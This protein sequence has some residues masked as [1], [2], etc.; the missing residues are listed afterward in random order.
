MNDKISLTKNDRIAIIKINRLEYRNALDG[1]SINEF[2]NVVAFFEADKT[3]QVLVLTGGGGTFCAGADLNEISDLG[4][5]YKPWAGAD[6]PLSKH[7]SKPVIA[8]I[9]GHPVAGGLGL[10]LWADIRV[11]SETAIF[12]V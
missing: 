12:E 7:C 8:T 2:A 1:K 10:A 11:A 5:H 9:E 6:G 4:A 3:T